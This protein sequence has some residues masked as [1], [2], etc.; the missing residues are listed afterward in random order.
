MPRVVVG[1]SSHAVLLWSRKLLRRR[2]DVSRLPSALSRSLHRQSVRGPQ[3][4]DRETL[5]DR[6]LVAQFEQAGVVAIPGL[7]APGLCTDVL[8]ELQRQLESSARPDF[9][10]IHGKDTRLDL[11]LRM[12]GPICDALVE[13][14]ERVGP[15]LRQLVGANAHLVELSA[16]QALPGAT[17]QPPHPDAAGSGDPGEAR[18]VTVF[19]LLTEV[20]PERGPLEVWLGSHMPAGKRM[21]RTQLHAFPSQ[22]MT[23]PVGTVVI[24]DART[25]H[26][27]T[28]NTSP[29]PRPVIYASWLSPGTRPDG[30]TWSMHHSVPTTLTL[31]L[32]SNNQTAAER[33]ERDKP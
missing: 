22:R 11:P 27:G 12:T 4:D 8:R 13:V 7:L 18:L 30:P 32:L 14:A 29:W 19:V 2:T 6:G 5:D 1:E 3:G 31:D 21:R 9:G 26:R 28:A 10:N 16:I 24:M 17:E 15:M 33:S 23:G 20:S 25:W